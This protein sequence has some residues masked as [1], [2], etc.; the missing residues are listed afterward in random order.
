M[1]CLN[2]VCHYSLPVF[3]YHVSTHKLVVP[4]FSSMYYI[5]SSSHVDKQTSSSMCLCSINKSLSVNGM[6][7]EL[8]AVLTQGYS[9]GMGVVY[10]VS[11]NI[12]S[13]W[14]RRKSKRSNNKHKWSPHTQYTQRSALSGKLERYATH[15]GKMTRFAFQTPCALLLFRDYH[16]P[17]PLSDDFFASCLSPWSTYISILINQRH[18]FSCYGPWIISTTPDTTI[19]PKKK[20]SLACCSYPVGPESRAIHMISLKCG[21]WTP[22]QQ[23]TKLT[24]IY[25][26]DD[27]YCYYSF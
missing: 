7:K 25:R 24:H 10:N 2:R 5:L 23:Q 9:S 16:Y 15:L 19:Q 22:I 26:Y 12:P 13:F 1:A 4:L 6:P 20:L 3:F 17:S 14:S 8:N 11:H 27:F 18:K 21:T